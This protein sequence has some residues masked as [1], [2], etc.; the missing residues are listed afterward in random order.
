MSFGLLMVAAAVTGLAMV[1]VHFLLLTRAYQLKL[2]AATSLLIAIGMMSK[3]DNG[4]LGK[5]LFPVISQ[6]IKELDAEAYRRWV[7][8]Y[9]HAP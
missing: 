9:G 6:A 3:R 7:S 1:A 5:Q 4:D 8:V 2:R